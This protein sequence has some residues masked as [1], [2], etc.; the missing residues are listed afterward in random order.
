MVVSFQLEADI[1]YQVDCLNFIL[2]ALHAFVTHSL[3]NRGK[4]DLQQ[5]A[6]LSIN[7][8]YLS[9]AD[10]R[11]RAAVF[12]ANLKSLSVEKFSW[13]PQDDEA[14]LEACRLSLP[15]NWLSVAV[16]V[17]KRSALSCRARHIQLTGSLQTRLKPQNFPP[18]DFGKPDEQSIRDILE[19]RPPVNWSL[20][21]SES[22]CM[23]QPDRIA[24][25]F[26]HH[27]SYE[28]RHR[29]WSKEEDQTLYRAVKVYGTGRWCMISSHIPLRSD[30]QCRE[31]WEDVLKAQVC[32]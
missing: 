3:R 12:S 9:N 16:L 11:D 18:T 19:Y 32:D 17:G 23:H 31:R 22:V 27:E 25:R 5:S 28:M 1:S 8:H 2:A 26:R 13:E 6:L 10:S 14:L 30:V 7:G 21:A 24:R 20:I 4:A 29:R 15:E